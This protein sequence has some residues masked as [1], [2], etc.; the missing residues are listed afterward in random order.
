MTPD[1]G[2]MSKTF[3]SKPDGVARRVPHSAFATPYDF[4]PP[5]ESIDLRCFVFWEDQPVE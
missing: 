5:R 4:G 1:D 3:D 2:L